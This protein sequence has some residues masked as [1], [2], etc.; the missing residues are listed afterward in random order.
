MKKALYILIPLLLITLLVS[1]FFIF[2]KPVIYSLRPA[3]PVETAWRLPNND[4]I[5][6]AS[7]FLYKDNSF[8]LM[9]KDDRRSGKL[10][11]YFENIKVLTPYQLQL[12]IIK[13]PA[14]HLDFFNYFFYKK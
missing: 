8:E 5:G 4:G 9:N 14:E 1:L 12:K 3:K 7:L 11:N 10:N 6:E 13:K 2:K